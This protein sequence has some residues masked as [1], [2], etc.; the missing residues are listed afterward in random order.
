MPVTTERVALRRVTPDD[1]DLLVEL[2]SDPEVMR[3]LTGGVPTPRA[4]IADDI[5]PAWLGYH[6]RFTSY[7]FWIAEARDDG[8]F[9][10]WFHLRPRAGL[11]QDEPEIGYR[12][13]RCEWGKGFAPEVCRALIDLAFSELGAVRVY[14]GTMAVNTASRRVME[15]VGLRFA[16]AYHEDFPYA[17]DGA[18]H[19]EVEYELRLEEWAAGRE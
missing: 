11:P 10:G 1:A 15:K 4:E 5:I 17:I 18:E 6:E 8:R 12:L 16:R 3:Y 9:L 14:A 7:G 19:G 2:D 13:R